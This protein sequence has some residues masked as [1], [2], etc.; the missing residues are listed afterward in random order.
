MPIQR[1]SNGL[2][3]QSRLVT[4]YVPYEESSHDQNIIPS[5]NYNRNQTNDDRHRRSTSQPTSRNQPTNFQ[6][7][8]GFSTSICSLFHSNQLHR[9]DCCALACCGLLLYER[10]Q[11]L[12]TGERPESIV[13]QVFRHLLIPVGLF[14]G[15]GFAALHIQNQS[16]NELVTSILF[17]GMVVYVFVD[18]M[19]YRMERVEFRKKVAKL[20]QQRN[21]PQLVGSTDP[22]QVFLEQRDHDASCAHRICGFYSNDAE[23]TEDY[24]EDACTRLWNIF[25]SI[26]CGS[27]CHCWFQLAGCCATAQ[28]SREIR[29][30]FDE[31]HHYIDYVTFEPFASY[32]A[33]LHGLRSTRDNR[34]WMHYNALSSLSNLLIKIWIIIIGSLFVLSLMETVEFEIY[35]FGVVVFTFFQAFLLLYLVHWKYNRFDISFDAVIKYFAVGFV[36]TSG[37]AIFF[38]FIE[39]VFLQLL[40]IIYVA[41]TEYSSLSDAVNDASAAGNQTITF[42]SNQTHPLVVILYLVMNSFALAALVEELCKYFGY[43]MLEHPDFISMYNLNSAVRSN[44]IHTKE[45]MERHD[46]A[47][48]IIESSSSESSA[49]DCE[50]ETERNTSNR[51]E[52]PRT[53]TSMACG[54]TV[55]MV[56][57]ATG[58]A[59]CE[60]LLYVFFYSP[61]NGAG[62]EFAV[63]V[64]RSIFPLH[65]LCAAIQ[66]IG[67]IRRDLEGDANYKL[68]RCLLPSIML[69][70]SFDF[71]LMLINYLATSNNGGNASD[72]AD[73]GDFT[74]EYEDGTISSW[75]VYVSFPCSGLLILLGSANYIYQAN[76]QRKRLIQ[77]DLESDKRS[78]GFI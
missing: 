32:M 65:P 62:S 39:S 6:S 35:N 41:I 33:D 38:E 3:T 2:M 15:A 8:K 25:A 69:H 64:A 16:T 54:I 78:S 14:L 45:R 24:D 44:R 17:M 60:N 5:H 10:N 18:C 27:A 55:A 58:F 28:E 47:L 34:F 50:W 13:S 20:R 7:H 22:S 56:C 37:L 48:Q 52:M 9:S 40:F 49:S 36:L 23:G 76:L 70:G 63:L 12:V 19:F 68:G 46:T 57:V 11:Y 67:I 30:A 43:F 4:N 73:D 31:N 42:M 53:I 61:S 59:C 51:S 72:A 75:A 29:S 21:A 77:M 71:M 26:C 74:P 66:S 1:T